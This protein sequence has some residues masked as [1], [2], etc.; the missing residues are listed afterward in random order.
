M[1]P[2]SDGGHLPLLHYVIQ[3]N[4]QYDLYMVDTKASYIDNVQMFREAGKD[5]IHQGYV[6]SDSYHLTYYVDT[7]WVVLS[8]TMKNFD[9]SKPYTVSLFP[10]PLTQKFPINQ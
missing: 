6:D 9:A 2:L 10:Q 3:G 4:Q 1:H 7:T 8:D 5:P